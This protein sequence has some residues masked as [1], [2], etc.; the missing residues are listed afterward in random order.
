MDRDNSVSASTIM[1]YGD[2]GKFQYGYYQQYPTLRQYFYFYSVLSKLFF[3]K[4]KLQ[5]K[6]LYYFVD[7]RS[8]GGVSLP[9]IPGAFIFLK[10]SMYE[11]LKGFDERFFLFFEDVDLSRRLNKRGRLLLNTSLRVKHLGASSMETRTNYKIYGYFILSFLK[12]YRVTGKKIPYLFLSFS[13]Y[14]NSIVKIILEYSKKPF[15]L[16]DANVIKVHRY[17]L[18]NFN[19]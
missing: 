2:D 3:K 12:Y 4:E 7:E 15:G 16:S 13:V 6:H 18:S 1:L 14:T 8:V 17:I 11:E 5:K 9:Q 10:K 19:N